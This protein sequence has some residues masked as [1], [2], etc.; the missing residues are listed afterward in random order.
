MESCDWVGAEGIRTG[1]K[2]RPTKKYTEREHRHN[3]NLRRE[4]EV[5]NVDKQN[6]RFCNWECFVYAFGWR[7]R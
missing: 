2:A 3:S 4:D 6:L 1:P 5:H 7:H